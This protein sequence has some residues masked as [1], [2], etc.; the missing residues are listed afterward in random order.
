M[1]L[2]PWSVGPEMPIFTQKLEEVGAAGARMGPQGWTW[3]WSCSSTPCGR[4]VAEA[5]VKACPPL[6]A[7]YAREVPRQ[8]L[9]TEHVAKVQ[10]QEEPKRSGGNYGWLANSHFISAETEARRC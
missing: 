2:N 1:S 9:S 7:R 3:C 8:G 10:A 4:C 6:E 5:V